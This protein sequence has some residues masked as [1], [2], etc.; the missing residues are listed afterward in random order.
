MEIKVK[1][2]IRVQWMKTHNEE[3]QTH[4]KPQG[5]VHTGG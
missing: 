1:G 5:N 2:I 3:N 4:L